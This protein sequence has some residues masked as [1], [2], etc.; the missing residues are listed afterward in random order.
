GLFVVYSLIAAPELF[1]AR[2]A[3]SPALWRDD[4]A[5][6]KQL[7]AFLVAHPRLRSQLFLSLGSDENDK[8]KAAFIHAREVLSRQAPPAL[9]WKAQLTRGGDHGN[10]AQ[11]AT[12]VALRDVYEH[13]TPT[14]RE[15]IAGHNVAPAAATP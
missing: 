3:H 9:A 15:P 1:D 8:M 10:N 14:G 7:D 5:L 13:W 4:E 12:P 2:F 11:L 6:L